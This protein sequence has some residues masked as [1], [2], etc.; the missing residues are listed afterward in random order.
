MNKIDRASLI[1]NQDQLLARLSRNNTKAEKIYT[2]HTF[3]WEKI[4]AK[5]IY[6]SICNIHYDTYNKLLLTHELTIGLLKSLNTW[7]VPLNYTNGHATTPFIEEVV[8]SI[9]FYRAGI[10]VGVA[11][12]GRYPA[13]PIKQIAK[14]KKALL[15][16]QHLGLEKAILL[17]DSW[18]TLI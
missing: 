10:D 6:E 1:K 12:H 15:L 5:T 2:Y 13:F 7:V 8:R 11:E 14:A 4:I 18:E 17:F 9:L 16:R 3:Y